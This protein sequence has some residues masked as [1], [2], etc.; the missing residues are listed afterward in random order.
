MK[1]EFARQ[2][3]ERNSNIK[4]NQNPSTGSLVVACGWAGGRTHTTKLIVF[5][6]NF[7]KAPKVMITT[8]MTVTNQSKII[9][10][11]IFEI[12]VFSTMILAG[13]IPFPAH[14][15]HLCCHPVGECHSFSEQRQ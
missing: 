3:F 11:K 13:S 12:S 6:R 2:T 1:L 10:K 5:F 14:L 4:F 15:E 9:K 8:I 7:E